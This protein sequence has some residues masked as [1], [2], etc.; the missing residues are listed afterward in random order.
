MTE[1][2][3][4]EPKTTGAAAMGDEAYARKIAITISNY[5]SSESRFQAALK[6]VEEIRA[7]AARIER[8]RCIAIVDQVNE[9]DDDMT[10]DSEDP[11]GDACLRIVQRIRNPRFP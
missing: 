3:V 9:H 5:L 8:E 6:L 2:A 1:P 10:P 11:W 7:D 4:A